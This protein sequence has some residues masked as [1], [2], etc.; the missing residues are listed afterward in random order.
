MNKP[1]T[2]NEMQI[3]DPTGHTTVGWDVDVPDEVENARKTFTD[4]VRKGYQA[5]RV[6]T[7]GRQAERLT[8]FDP[9][10]EKMVM[11]PQ[12]KGG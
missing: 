1:L 6:G 12:L 11:I 10:A 9:T 2:K 7:S 8:E 3:M 4:M 5:F